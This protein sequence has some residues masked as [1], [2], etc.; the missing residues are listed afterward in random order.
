MASDL[1]PAPLDVA[2]R[3]GRGT[4]RPARRR[5]LL[6]VA[7]CLLLA[8][9]AALAS[10]TVGWKE[11]GLPEVLGA[12]LA[13][14]G[15]AAANIVLEARMPRTLVGLVIGVCLA[16]A[17]ALIQALTRNPLADPGL[18]GVDAGA[19]LAIV[20]GLLSF[21]AMSVTSYIWFAFGGALAAT[22]AV[23]GIAAAGRRTASPVRLTLAGV[24]LGAVLSGVIGAITVL[25]RYVFQDLMHWSVGSLVGRTIPQIASVSPFWLAGV[26]LAVAL[27]PALNAVA[28][29]DDLAVALGTKVMRTRVL[30][31]I[32][33][34]LLAG[35]AT[36]L[37]GPVAFVGLMVPHAA[38]WLVG[39]DQRWILA[40]SLG[41]G[42][43]LVL[44]ADV[45][46][47]TLL[48]VGEVPVGIVIPILGAPVLIALVRRRKVIGL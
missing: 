32:A 7:A 11:L 16:W 22:F 44:L 20:L 36:T 31:V 4:T 46:G 41:L 6:G 35:T 2:R 21:G 39:Q 40:G 38:R 42:P 26:A 28:L 23:Y 37:A 14:D 47:R 17:G 1:A 5:R 43:A 45:A 34:T 27:A 24:A 10:V 12:L 3:T 19:G 48:P 8:A 25:N 13:N 9:L 15:S 30:T 18:L 29:G 33:V